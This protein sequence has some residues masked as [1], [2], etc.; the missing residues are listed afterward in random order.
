MTNTLNVSTESNVATVELNR[1]DAYNTLSLEM[2]DRLPIV[3][4]DLAQDDNIRCVVLTGSGDKAFCAGGDISGL[5]GDGAIGNSAKLSQQVEAWAQASLILHEMPKPTLA[6]INGVAAGAGMSLALACDLRIASGNAYFK[7]AFANMAMSGDFGGSYFLTQLVGPS[8]A[9]ELYFLSER[10]D[11][12]NA[13]AMNLVNWLA[14][15]DELKTRTVQMAQRLAAMPLLTWRN[16]KQNLNIA[17]TQDLASVLHQEA[18]GMIET[19]M[20][21]ETRAA[22]MRF[23]SKEE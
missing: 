19:A 8:K 3:L 7:T 16:M 22:A 14:P 4:S 23:F 9:R 11:A 13:L 5:S 17:L 15:H 2:L 1:P 21:E 10:I 12:D 20:S 6:S 18:I